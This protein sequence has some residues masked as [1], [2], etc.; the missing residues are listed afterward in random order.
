MNVNTFKRSLTNALLSIDYKDPKLRAKVYFASLKAIN[1]LTAGTSHSYNRNVLLKALDELEE[2][3]S[4]NLTSKIIYEIIDPNTVNFKIINKEELRAETTRG[5]SFGNDESISAKMDTAATIPPKTLDQNH[6]E[7]PVLRKRLTDNKMLL[8]GAAALVL[9]SVSYAAFSLYKTVKAD[10]DNLDQL[11]LINDNILFEADFFGDLSEFDDATQAFKSKMSVKPDS[12]EAQI[13]G[14]AVFI[15]KDAIPVD[16][17]EIYQMEIDVKFRAIEN[18]KNT[19]FY[20]GFIT[21]DKNKKIETQPPGSHRYFVA[22]N[23]IP[24]STPDEANKWWTLS[25]FI[26]GSQAIRTAFR[27]TT[28]Y[29]KPFILVN[30]KQPKQTVLLRHVTVTKVQ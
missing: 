1:K 21:M 11:A 8:I 15:G 26:T 18:P 16:R 24:A 13:V 23:Q 14:R 7:K 27:P 10:G 4:A 22:A 3:I 5:S 2:E 29:V 12:R 28:Q 25:G 6:F 17:N 20:A 30:N 19:G 9:L